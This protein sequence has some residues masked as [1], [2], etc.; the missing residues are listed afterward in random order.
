MLRGRSMG[1]PILTLGIISGALIIG[2]FSIPSFYQILPGTIEFAGPGKLTGNFVVV[3][4]ALF[5][6]VPYPPFAEK[7]GSA[8]RKG[9]ACLVA[10][11][12]DV[13][14]TYAVNPFRTADGRG[15]S[16]DGEC[17]TPDRSAWYGYC[18]VAERQ[19]WVRPGSGKPAAPELAPFCNRSIDHGTLEWPVGTHSA[20]W[21]PLQ[22]NSVPAATGTIHWRTVA[23]HNI[24][25]QCVDRMGDVKP[26]P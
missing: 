9:G 16:N 20:N 21:W 24:D 17:A 19:C 12:A 23:C 18:A 15:C 5:K 6:F 13:G 2:A 3:R 26:V 10:L 22:L 1:H 14:Y 25:G 8:S 4:S 11:P 7:V